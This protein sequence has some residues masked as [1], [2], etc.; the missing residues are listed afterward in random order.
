MTIHGNFAFFLCFFSM[1]KFLEEAV[2]H[3]LLLFCVSV[4]RMFICTKGVQTME[5]LA[6]LL[7]EIE[8]MYNGKEVLTINEQAIYENARIGIVGDNGSG[9]S[10]LLKLL[11][12][13][14]LPEKGR[15]DRRIDFK[16]FA[17]IDTV[18]QHLVE[19]IDFEL[20]SRFRVPNQM[21][22]FSGGEETK[23]R[24]A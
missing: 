10:T 14:I 3:R 8:I 6:M 22:P 16:Y 9:K 23:Y 7:K 15:V 11:A 21:A 13:E 4:R 2:F 17:Q 12:G 24:L 18:G 19:E 5:A 1:D 20:L